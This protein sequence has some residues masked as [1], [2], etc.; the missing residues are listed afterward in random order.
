ML[1]KR[2][3]GEIV[4]LIRA[5]AILDLIVEVLEHLNLLIPDEEGL[6]EEIKAIGLKLGK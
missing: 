5:E 2:T 1:K 4:G 6:V 3:L